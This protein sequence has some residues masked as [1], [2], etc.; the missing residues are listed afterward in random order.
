M[1]TTTIPVAPDITAQMPDSVVPA[2][3]GEAYKHA[4]T[5]R[6][7]CAAAWLDRGFRETVLKWFHEDSRHRATAP[8]FGVD[9]ATVVHQCE[10]ARSALNSREVWLLIP[11][12]LALLSL[13]AAFV[14]GLV[15]VYLI[16]F[17][18]CFVYTSRARSMATKNFTRAKF[19]PDA[20]PD[21]SPAACASLREAES[22]NC[23][24]YSGFTPFVGSGE[25][26][27]GWSFALDLRK[28]ADG[29]DEPLV[30]DLSQTVVAIGGDPGDHISLADLYARVD[31]DICDLHLDRVFID[32][33]LYINGRD[34]RDDRRF[35]DSPLS[36]PRNRVT[37]EVMKEAMLQHTE[38]KLRHYRCIRVID[39]NGEQVL[40]IFL[41]FSKLSHNLFVEA[42]YF[43]LTPV[44][45][46][47][48]K[49]DSLNPEMTFR[50]LLE[51]TLLAAFAAPFL[52][53]LA[54]FTLLQRGMEAFQQS[55]K[56]RKEEKQILDDPSFDYGAALSCRQWASSHQYQ[57]YFQKLDK[58][59][60]LKVLEKNIL[61][62]ILTFLE[63]NNV[64]VS[65]LKQRQTMILNNGVIV[66]GGSMTTEN[67]AVGESAKIDN[68]RQKVTNIAS[69]TAMA[70]KQAS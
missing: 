16:A 70:G 34:I 33:K 61:D 48:R 68:L 22:G 6:L 37:S 41:R 45:D 38:Q 32:D 54:P 4:E 9:M 31:R 42:S 53:V 7:L 17:A 47:F 36:C 26:I 49:V 27:G 5:T 46:R 13:V 69:R 23:L 1:S 10:R 28:R 63:S 15:L 20:L 64:D 24:V 11:A 2:T 56:Q 3:G 8:S 14:P 35:I 12:V 30:G 62:S 18:I 55:A 66:S 52:T 40:S 43:L 25:N 57:R 39:W 19:N 58:E 21:E 59:M 50:R 44:G 51:T 60:Y 67:L 65:E 29:S